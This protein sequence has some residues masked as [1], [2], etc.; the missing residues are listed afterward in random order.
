[1]RFAGLFSALLLVLAGTALAGSD[2][3]RYINGVEGLRAASIP[4]PGFYWRNYDL[5]Y[6]SDKLTDKD[7]DKMN[8]DF[9]L[10]LVASVHRFVYVNDFPQKVLGANYGAYLVVPTYY[11]SLEV[12]AMGVDD[13]RFRVGDIDLCPLLLTWNK[14]RFDA[15]VAY[16]VM[17]PTGDRDLGEPAT[18]GR[19]YWSHMISAGGTGYLDKEK[20]WTFS[21]LGRYEI[22]HQRGCD[23]T[24]MGDQF[25]LEWG[26]GKAFPKLGLEVGIVGYAAWQ[27]TDDS[28]HGVYWDKSV[29]DR[30]FAVG[31]EVN[32]MIKPVGLHMALRF[33]KE[34]GA[35]DHTEGHIL[36]LTLTKKF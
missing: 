14:A 10:D 22:N 24:R 25:H 30:V 36:N 29:R 33:G 17:M 16:E 20:T 19:E 1:M 13:E 27:T 9:N 12:G 8:V 11:A 4:P 32:Y 15:A 5:W 31:P 3:A 7:G 35:R 26:A 28:G 21:L 2:S 18:L 6:H 23:H 34:F